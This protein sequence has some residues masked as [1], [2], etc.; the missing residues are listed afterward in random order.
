[1]TKKVSNKTKDL[2]WLKFSSGA[3][4]LLAGCLIISG[5]CLLA[6]MWL[7]GLVL[8]GV[9]IFV[10]IKAKQQILEYKMSSGYIVHQGE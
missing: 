10:L 3:Y 5:L 2:F 9:G 1:M 7:L 6:F 4:N 8:I